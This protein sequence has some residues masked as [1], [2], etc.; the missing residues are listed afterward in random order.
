M[1][2]INDNQENTTTQEPIGYCPRC[3]NPIIEGQRGF[4]CSNYKAGCSFVLWKTQKK[5]LFK[6][7]VITPEMA[8]KLLSGETLESELLYSTKKDKHFSGK[9]VM[10][11]RGPRTSESYGGVYLKF[12]VDKFITEG[13]EPLGKC[14]RC[15][16]FV[17]EGESAYLCEGVNSGCRFS[18]K[19]QAKGGPLRNIVITPEMAKHL[20]SGRTV[21]VQYGFSL[22]THRPIKFGFYMVDKGAAY[23]TD[24]TIISVGKATRCIP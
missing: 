8:S 24:F 1:G 16:K 20:L 7:V 14:P 18:I 6:D 21:V 11:D 12:V 19:K 2:N 23:G 4:G 5:G 9:F 10:E 22:K 15:K 3:G 13:L 17:Y